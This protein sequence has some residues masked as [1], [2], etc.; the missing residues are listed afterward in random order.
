MNKVGL[1]ML[2]LCCYFDSI[3]FKLLHLSYSTIIS[4]NEKAK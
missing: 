4:S 1:D 2:D 3:S